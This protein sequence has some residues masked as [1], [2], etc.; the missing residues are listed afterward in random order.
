MATILRE[1]D[2]SPVAEVAKKRK[3]STQAIYT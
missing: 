1:V 2:R 3:G